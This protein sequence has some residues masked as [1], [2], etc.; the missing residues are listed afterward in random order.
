MLGTKQTIGIST[1]W[2]K[3]TL[4]KTDISKYVL[5]EK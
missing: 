1:V 2:K 5:E 3:K 4:L